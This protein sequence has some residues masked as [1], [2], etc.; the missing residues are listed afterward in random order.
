V[1]ARAETPKQA[2][3]GLGHSLGG[4]HG[5][6]SHLGSGNS[7]EPWLRREMLEDTSHLGEEGSRVVVSP[8][9]DE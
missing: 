2:R 8:V 3:R 6:R 9:S 5:R 1:T 4:R 7:F